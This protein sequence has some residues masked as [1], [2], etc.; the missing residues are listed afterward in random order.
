MVLQLRWF[1][2]LLLLGR[3]CSVFMMVLSLTVSLSWDVRDT[4]FKDDH[5]GASEI[6]SYSTPR[7]LRGNRRQWSQYQQ[8]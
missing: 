1:S 3:W 2:L 7:L 5:T 4:S 8:R 6:R